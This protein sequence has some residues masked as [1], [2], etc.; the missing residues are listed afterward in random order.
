MGSHINYGTGRG[1][2]YKIIL[3]INFGHSPK[4]NIFAVV[5]VIYLRIILIVLLF[6][7][8]EYFH[9]SIL[10]QC[11]MSNGIFIWFLSS[12][13]LFSVSNSIKLDI[14]IETFCCSIIGDFHFCLLFCLLMRMVI[15][16]LLLRKHSKIWKRSPNVI[17]W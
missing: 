17:E 14:G 15:T 6:F 1:I 12:H 16:F 7:C 2:T 10:T 4:E 13:F 5:F 9:F 8:P 11:I 3:D